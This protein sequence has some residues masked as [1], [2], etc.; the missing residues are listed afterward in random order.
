VYG[1]F[2]L[3]RHQP[4]QKGSFFTKQVSGRRT[5]PGSRISASPP[6]ERHLSKID[7][8]LSEMVEKIPCRMLSWKDVQAMSLDLA[9]K[10][11]SAGFKPDVIVAVARG[12]LIGA[13]LVADVLGVPDF[14]CLRIAHWGETA[15]RGKEAVLERGIGGSVE[16]KNVL[17]VDDITDTGK[18][19]SVAKSYLE[20]LKPAQVKTAA[21]QHI[22][23]SSFRPDFFGKEEK[24]WAWFSYPWNR[25]EDLRSLTKRLML[26]TGKTL[27]IDEIQAGFKQYFGIELSPTLVKRTLRDLQEKGFGQIKSN[28]FELQEVGPRRVSPPFGL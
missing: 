16:G 7:K 18:S 13:R 6:S 2:F 8:T 17:L 14:T 10:V 5:L 4:Q 26:E 21:L 28:A 27:T 11:Q 22:S 15:V 1:T 24:K 3:A 25:W 19:L 20:T 12:G 23:G 9:K